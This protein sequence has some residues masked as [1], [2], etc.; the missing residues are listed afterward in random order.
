MEGIMKAKHVVV[1]A[2]GAIA[3]MIVVCTMTSAQTLTKLTFAL[4][5][6]IGGQHTP[7]FYT[8]RQGYFRDQGLDVQFVPGQ[9]PATVQQIAAGTYD[10]GFADVTFLIEFKGN[11]PQQF[12]VKEV[13]MVHNNNPNSFLTLKKNHISD[14]ADL[15]GKRI[16]ASTFSGQKK[17]WPILLKRMHLP[18]DYITWVNYAPTLGEQAVVRGEIDAAAGYPNNAAIMMSAGAKMEDIEVIS[19]S[20]LGLDMYGDGIVAN[21]KFLREHPDIVRKFVLA[22]NRGLRESV[23]RPDVAVQAVLDADPTLVPAIELAKFKLIIPF[24]VTSE[25]RKSGFGFIDTTKLGRQISDMYGAYHLKAKPSID[26]V[27][28]PGFLP[29]DSQRGVL[30]N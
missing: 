7:F 6:V 10:M 20:S 12:D 19:F 24:M 3:M 11:N 15:K 30:Q 9:G 4:D 18:D 2:L 25:V 16:A 28:A 1:P 27:Y 21:G 22:F 13:Y 14:L 26:D 29:P 17:A 8:L 23:A 5:W